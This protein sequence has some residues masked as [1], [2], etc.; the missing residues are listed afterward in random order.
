M[1]IIF[2]DLHYATYFASNSLIWDIELEGLDFDSLT[3]E[4]ARNDIWSSEGANMEGRFKFNN[5]ST[6]LTDLCAKSLGIKSKVL[7][8]IYNT[9]NNIF[10]ERWFKGIDFYK[11][12]TVICPVLF[13]D[14][15]NI[16][17]GPHLDN[18]HIVAQM[19]VNLT[20]NQYG[21]DFYNP[22]TEELIYTS[23]GKRGQGV[24]FFNNSSAVHGMRNGNF[25]RYIFYSNIILD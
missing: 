11:N 9:D 20:D 15:P 14:S 24:L 6:I 25:D 8:H 23:S 16:R 21:T 19:V 17:M 2:K 3:P 18:G 1:D 22:M 13:K 5:E 4:L 7:D 10:R 12:H